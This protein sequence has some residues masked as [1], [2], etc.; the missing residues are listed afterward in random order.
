MLAIFCFPA[1]Q[2]FNKSAAAAAKDTNGRLDRHMLYQAMNGIN[3][4][5]R[6]PGPCQGPGTCAD[7]GQGQINP[8]PPN[9]NPGP[10]PNPGPN[11]PIQGPGLV[12]QVKNFNY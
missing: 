9:P 7:H 6:H 11:P 2:N 4:I 8:V 3:R 1:W 5:L 10:I 12:I